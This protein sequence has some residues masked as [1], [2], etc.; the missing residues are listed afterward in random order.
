[1]PTSCSGAE[2]RSRSQ[3]DREAPDPLD[4]RAG[5]LVA[6]LDRHRQALD[7]LGLGDLELGEGAFELAGA[8]LDL[9]LERAEAAQAKRVADAQRRTGDEQRAGCGHE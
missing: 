3:Q 7:R 5:V 1:L 9:V 6:E 4:V 2:W 8:A